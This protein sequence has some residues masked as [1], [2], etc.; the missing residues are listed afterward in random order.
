MAYQVPSAS[1]ATT[2]P[3]P[4]RPLPRKPAFN[5][6]MIASP[7][8]LARMEGGMILSG[9]K[10]CRGSTNEAKMRPVFLHSP[11]RARVDGQ[12]DTRLHRFKL[13]RQAT[14]LPTYSA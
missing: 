3:L 14:A 6:V 5:T 2:T 4:N 12:Y 8:A 11:E 10:A 1:L 13:K 9:P 7:L